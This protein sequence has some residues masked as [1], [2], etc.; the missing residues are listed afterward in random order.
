MISN[1]ILFTSCHLLIFYTF[2]KLKWMSV[3]NKTR[4]YVVIWMSI[5][6]KIFFCKNYKNVIV[7][8]IFNLMPISLQVYWKETLS[9]Q[10]SRHV[11]L[12]NFA[13]NVLS[14]ALYSD[15]IPGHVSFSISL[16]QRKASFEDFLL[17]VDDCY[18][19]F[20]EKLFMTF[21]NQSFIK[22]SLWS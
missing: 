17:W 2:A 6:K 4:S 22:F 14:S 16:K 19:L 12:H 11:T 21:Q 7:I 20:S 18:F 3:T 9:Q 1:G 13:L 15:S 10:K 8:R 5:R